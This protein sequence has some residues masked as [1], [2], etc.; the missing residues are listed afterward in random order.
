M[1]QVLSLLT[2]LLICIQ[3]QAQFKLGMHT[4]VDINNIK[5]TG[6]PEVLTDIKQSASFA[7]F[8]I[9]G[10]YGFTQEFSLKAELNHSKKGFEI[11]ETFEQNILGINIP[12]GVKA[13]TSLSVIES[14]ILVS[15]S[16]PTG[17]VNVFA[18]AG[19]VFSY[20]TGGQIEPVGA[21]GLDFNLP[22]VELNFKQDG[23]ERFGV[24]AAI[25]IGVETNVSDQVS[26][27]GRTR[28]THSFT[29]ILDNPIVDIKTR[30]NTIHLGLG[31]SYTL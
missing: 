23:Y 8:G 16:K 17:P 2:L 1:K 12:I 18:E 27:F 28:F 22:E 5:I 26:V 13:R 9:H 29:D 15:Y 20:A 31:L 24:G 25:G 14:P 21:F 19:P 3:T 4:G 11:S 7:T 6:I 10:S 30:A